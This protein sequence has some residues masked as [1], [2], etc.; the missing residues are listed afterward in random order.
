VLSPQISRDKRQ[1]L[2]TLTSPISPTSNNHSPRLHMQPAHTWEHKRSRNKSEKKV[3]VYTVQLKDKKGYLSAP[4]VEDKGKNYR[5]HKKTS[6]VHL[7]H[8]EN[9]ARCFIAD[10]CR[11]SEA[12]RDCLHKSPTSRSYSRSACV[13]IAI[14]LRCMIRPRCPPKCTREA[15]KLSRSGK[16]GQQ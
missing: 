7:F 1:G 11:L 14:E 9:L 2:S 16:G 5:I 15:E 6:L 12:K 13:L 8:P 4:I 10:S 3:V